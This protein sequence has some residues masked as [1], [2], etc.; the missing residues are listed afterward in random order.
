M[1]AKHSSTELRS[2][3]GKISTTT[4]GDVKGTIEVAGLHTPAIRLS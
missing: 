4:E 1:K 3:L 2:K